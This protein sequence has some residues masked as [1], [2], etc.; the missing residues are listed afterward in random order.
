[1]RTRESAASF[2]MIQWCTGPLD[3]RRED[4]IFVE[5]SEV[6]RVLRDLRDL[7]IERY[8]ETRSAC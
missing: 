4:I 6:G 5:V 1:M 7:I 8:P 2:Q 3:A